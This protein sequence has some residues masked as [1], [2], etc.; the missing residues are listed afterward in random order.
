LIHSTRFDGFGDEVVTVYLDTSD[1]SY[2][3]KGRG[4]AAA[5]GDVRSARERLEA[6]IRAERV[7]LLVSFVHLAEIAVHDETAEAALAWLDRGLAVWCFTTPSVDIFR[8]E[9]LGER[10]AVEAEPLSRSKLESSRFPLR[11]AAT[12]VSAG[13]VARGVRRIARGYSYAENLGK[14]AARR[15]PGTTAKRHADAQREQARLVDLILKGEH[16]NLPLVA[17]AAAVTLT[18][19]MRWAAARAGLTLDDVRAQLRLPS[20]CSWFSGTLPPATWEKAAKRVRAQP[21]AAPA[22]ALRIAI[23]KWEKG[24]AG[25]VAQ[26]GVLYDVQHL[27]YAARCDFATIDGPNFRATTKVREALSRP[28]FFPTARLLEVVE[29]LERAS[30]RPA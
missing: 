11:L 25:R 8:A 30:E 26:P 10:P 23:E 24:D 17:R 16:D 12:S 19:I 9:L 4:T 14:R 6:L 1:L 15:P 18:P 29:A 22:S 5:G 28:R 7:R 3:L 20:G 2:L 13:S 27:A 21:T